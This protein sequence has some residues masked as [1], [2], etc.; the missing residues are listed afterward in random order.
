MARIVRFH[1]LGGPEVL[2]LEE[3]PLAAPGEGEVRLQVK[4]LGLNRAEVVFRA[5]V[6]IEQ[7]KLPARLGYEA[8][9]MIDAVGPGV[10]GFQVGDR[11]STIPAFSM[12][13]YGVY[14]ESAIAPVHAIARIPNGLSFEQGAAIWMA[15]LTAYG[16]LVEYA[17]MKLGDYILL[18][19]ASS[20]VGYAAIQLVK[21]AGGIVIATTRTHAKKQNLLDAGADYVIATQEEDFVQRTM[22]ITNGHGADVIFD[23]IAGAFVNQL[24]EVAA[25]RTTIFIYGALSMDVNNTPFPMMAALSKG[26]TVKAYTLFE[27]TSNPEWFER[28]KAYI[29]DA[30]ATGKLSPIIDSQRFTLNDIVAAHRYMESNQQ[31]GKIVVTV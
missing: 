2:Q 24:A 15:Y 31:N 1:Q 7:A 3:M 17:H 18:T 30:L 23:P 27:V 26:L 12:N 5:G 9:G 21:A 8:A 20:S 4:A 16:A 6:Y 11:V 22:E 29:Y 13:Q 14:G 19:A 28:G 10:E 25:P